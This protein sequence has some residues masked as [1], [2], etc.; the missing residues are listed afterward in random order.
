MFFYFTEKIIWDENIVFVEYFFGE[1]IISIWKY[2]FG[3]LMIFFNKFDIIYRIYD[4][5][6]YY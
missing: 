2:N 1:G 5:D 4:V 6:F 3:N